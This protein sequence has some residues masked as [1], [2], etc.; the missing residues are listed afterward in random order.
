[1]AVPSDGQIHPGASPGAERTTL[2][3]TVAT[4]TREL[5]LGPGLTIHQAVMQAAGQLGVVAE[6]RPLNTTAKECLAQLGRS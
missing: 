4:L 5:E 2:A 1:V 6:G 3:A